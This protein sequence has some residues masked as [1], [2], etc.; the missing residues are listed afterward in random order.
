MPPTRESTFAGE[1]Y[2]SGGSGGLG[3]GSSPASGGDSGGTSGG[4]GGSG[5]AAAVTAFAAAQ[6]RGT[7][8]Y[9][10]PVT[11][12]VLD[13]PVRA[14]AVPVYPDEIVE[15]SPIG[16]ITANVAVSTVGP[17][18]ARYGPRQILTP[19]STPRVI[20]VSNIGEIWMIANVVG[21]GVLI[22]KRKR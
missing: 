22:T 7:I 8:I 13:E 12:A 5:G 1:P 2:P 9:E 16:G 19:S 20:A 11:L 3:G 21:E 6:G 14:P 17:S 18:A 4:S 15:V 10:I